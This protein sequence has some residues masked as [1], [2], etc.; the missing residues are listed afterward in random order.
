MTKYLSA[1]VLFFIF[2]VIYYIGSFTKIPFADCVGFVL[3]VENGEFETAATATSHFLYTNTAILI[4]NLL[5]L[6]AIEA[7][8]FLVV[9]SGAATVSVIYLTVKSITKTEWASITAAFV[10]GF[11][12]SFWRNAEIVEVYT[13]N[14]LWVSLF[15]FSTTKAFIEKKNIYIILSSLF[16]G[17]SLWVHIQNILLIPALLLFLFYFRQEKKYAYPAIVLF[18]VL[19]SSLF[20]LN[21]SQGLPFKSPYSSEQG[22]WV[23][24]SL[25]QTPVQLIKDFFISFIYLV[26][27]FNIFIFFGVAGIILLYRS[28]RKMFY[29]FF[30]A[31]LLVY[32]FSTFYIVSDN[33]VFFL[34]FN[35]I[36]A[37]SIGYGLSSTRYSS[38][39]KVSWI[40]LFIPLGYILCY[41]IA[42]S[43][44]KGKE[45]HAFKKYKGGMNYYLLPWMNNNEGILEFTI[46]KKTA[47][48]PIHWMTFSALEY[49]KVLKSKGYTEEE[50]KKL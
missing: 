48:E 40:C 50:I 1:T 33:Y 27:N 16:L 21:I 18:I 38:F 23:E 14:S 30:A 45:V 12:F 35:I 15:F 31:A 49:I 20:I 47:P 25:Q 46:D 41:N 13:Y 5:G 28:N 6:N 8:R 29:V 37:L 19:F 4:K 2:L 10:F 22:T 3:S 26:Y 34:P 32:G 43:T 24:D 36:F 9:A 42:L 11:S 44:E 39:K 17:I 7:S